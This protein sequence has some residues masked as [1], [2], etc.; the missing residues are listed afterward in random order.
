MKHRAIY[1]LLYLLVVLFAGSMQAAEESLALGDSSEIKMLYF[2]PRIAVDQPPL[3]I[4]VAGGS[5]N[6]F[7]AR[8]QFWMGK[9]LADRGWAVAVPIS[10]DGEGFSAATATFFPRML[11]LIYESHTLKNEKPLLAGVSSGGSAALEIAALHPELYLGVVAAPGR[12]KD[13]SELQQLNGLPVYLRI[14]EKDIFRWNRRLDEMS[15]QLVNAGAE[16]DAAL[17]PGARHVFQ[18]DWE[19][20]QIWLNQVQS[21]P[22]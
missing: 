19:N 20:L 13:D 9:E 21:N 3:A 16:V 10:P 1:N 11:E 12:L 7:L 18:L 2:E 17:V 5:S 15:T 14:A 22:R 6:E 4:L 8:A